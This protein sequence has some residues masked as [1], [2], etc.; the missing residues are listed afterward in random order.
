MAENEE[1]DRG[2]VPSNFL[3]VDVDDEAEE[4]SEV[5]KEEEDQDVEGDARTQS[6]FQTEPPSDTKR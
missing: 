4:K 5:M 6:D 3:R 2:M 1:G